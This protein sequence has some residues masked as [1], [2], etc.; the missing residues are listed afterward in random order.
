MSEPATKFEAALSLASAIEANQRQAIHFRNRLSA[1]ADAAHTLGL[2]ELS[3]TL[4]G[5]SGDIIDQGSRV[6]A[7]HK[8]AH[9]VL[10][11]ASLET[12]A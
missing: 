3:K 9:K 1:I 12:A 8:E 4:W 10:V 5:M 11:A 6:T 7:A 2:E